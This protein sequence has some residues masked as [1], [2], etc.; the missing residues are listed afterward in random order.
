LAKLPALNSIK[1]IIAFFQYKALP[2]L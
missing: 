2:H 1:K